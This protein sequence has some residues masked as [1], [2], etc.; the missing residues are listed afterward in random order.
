ML[1]DDD[2]VHLLFLAAVER[3]G[4]VSAYALKLGTSAAHISQI[5]NG[6]TRINGKVAADLMLESVNA[7]RFK[8]PTPSTE[9]E[10]YVN[11][12]RAWITEQVQNGNLPHYDPGKGIRSVL[13]KQA[14]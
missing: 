13:K 5:K 11:K 6:S 7:Y 12:R 1:L 10:D 14:D 4:G 8:M 9:Q 3:A 2:E